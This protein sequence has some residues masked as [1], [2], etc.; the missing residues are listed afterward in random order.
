MSGLSRLLVATAGTALFS[1]GT[2]AQ[3]IT[4]D[5][6]AG[7]L[8]RGYIFGGSRYGQVFTA[9]NDNVL[10][11]FT[12][13]LNSVG[14]PPTEFTAQL[15]PWE[16]ITF[17]SGTEIYSSASQS[18][19]GLPPYTG[20]P[21]GYGEITFNTGGI[22]LV[23]GQQYVAYLN[24]ETQ[25]SGAIGYNFDRDSY[26]EGYG[27]YYSLAQGF[28]YNAGDTHDYAF[29]ASFSLAPTSVPEPSKVF[30]LFIFGLGFLVQRGRNNPP[31]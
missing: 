6:T 15:A 3:A 19:A 11:S 23:A 12:F 9:P 1:V 24:V 14:S 21:S 17:E 31:V 10:D 16:P 8:G 28:W 22:S 4:I 27:L 25:G 2:V 29:K 26:S 30:G 5:T 13:F 7:W 18:V 20:T